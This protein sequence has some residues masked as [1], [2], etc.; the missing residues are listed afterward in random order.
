M[1]EQEY[2]DKLKDIESDYSKVKKGLY[3]EYAKSQIKFG[4]GDV[5]KD[6][7]GVIIIVKRYGTHF[8]FSMPRPVYIGVELNKNLSTKESGKESSIFGNDGVELLR[9]NI[10]NY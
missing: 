9:K 2:K 4:I 7:D 3:I 1:T 10:C 5:I 6:S 8:Y